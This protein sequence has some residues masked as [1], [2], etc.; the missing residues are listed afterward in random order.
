MNKGVLVAFAGIALITFSCGCEKMQGSISHRENSYA[1]LVIASD[2]YE[3]FTYLD[4]NGNFAG[5]DVEIARE[6]CKRLG[7]EPTFKQINWEEKDKL[8]EDGKIDCIWGSFSMTG[9]EEQYL[10]AGPYLSS[11]QVVMVR[12]D[13]GIEKLDDL[14]G[15]KIS[16]IIS[17]KPE[18]IFLNQKDKSIPRLKDIF[19][20]STMDEAVVALRKRYVDGVSGHES[21]LSR[22][23]KNEPGQYRILS[24]EILSAKLGVAFKK[25]GNKVLADALTKV[26]NEMKKDG[27]TRDIVEKYGLDANKIVGETDETE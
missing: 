26:L 11:R 6:A 4:D 1:K 5:I 23:E 25:K 2:N 3:P 15:K 10:W 27:T 9:R 17:S 12:S 14:K 16:V 22:Y 7:Y 20:F 13:S 19:S 24:P 21:A 18:E 8:L